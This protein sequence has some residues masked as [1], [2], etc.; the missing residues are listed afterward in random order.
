[1]IKLSGGISDCRGCLRGGPSLIVHCVLLRCRDKA[2]YFAFTDAA[3]RGDN[4]R[5][6]A[7][8][9]VDWEKRTGNAL[10]VVS[11]AVRSCVLDSRGEE[12]RQNA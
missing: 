10:S 11:S 1:M 3:A 8:I 6:T 7:F 9:S 5:F 2:L 4:V 12:T